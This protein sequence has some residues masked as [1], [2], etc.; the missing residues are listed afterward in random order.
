MFK[1]HLE[2]SEKLNNLHRCFHSYYQMYKQ[3]RWAF[4]LNRQV[5]FW[6]E[7][8]SLLK[9]FGFGEPYLV[10]KNVAGMCTREGTWSSATAN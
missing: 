3:N 10:K 7:L 8:T 4:K 2:V 5:Q 9:L 6:I 1:L